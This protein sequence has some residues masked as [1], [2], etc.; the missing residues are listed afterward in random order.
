MKRDMDF[1]RLLILEIE[2]GKDWYETTSDEIAE[3]LQVEARGLSK[4]D[5]E[6]LE[7][8]L[9]LLEDAGLAEFTKTGDGWIPE[10]L[11]W[12]GH[13]FADSVRDEEVWRK[14]KEGAQAA[15]G[16]TVDLLRALAKG[17]LKKQI[18]DR[19]GIALDL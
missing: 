6:R 13:D 12:A 18:E 7:Y 1:L 19:T 3:I 11:T 17:F 15:K 8:H 16:F 4:A 9:T 5:A 10:R 14:T 2:A